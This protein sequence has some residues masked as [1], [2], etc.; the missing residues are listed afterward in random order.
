MN[1]KI[2]GGKKLRQRVLQAVEKLPSMPQVMHKA[3]EILDSPHSSMADLANLIETDP[4][5]AMRVLRLSNSAYYS[6]LARVSSVQEAAVVLGLKTLG[7]L[8]TVAC[9]SKLLDR[10]LKGYDLQPKVLWRHSLSVA[11]GA[12]IIA[13]KK[14]PGLASEAFSAGL[15][16][17]AGKIILDEY[18]LERKEEFSEFLADGEETFLDAEQEILGFDHAE[19]AARVCEKWSFPK[20]ISVAIKYHHYPSRLRG[21]NLAFI[22]YVADQLAMWSGMDTDGIT[23]DIEDKAFE[24]L[25]VRVNEIEPII[26]EIVTSVDQITEE[27][28]NQ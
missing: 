9:S 20:S 11:V 10:S 21:N 4:A 13:N 7:E 5:L 3:R 6:R 25:D 28:E 8:L 17:D 27:M 22:V 23:I 12:R 2:L 26:D 14:Q 18:V 19:I 16:H 15:I 24:R 1:G